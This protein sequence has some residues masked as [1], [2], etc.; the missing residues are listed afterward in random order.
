MDSQTSR[1]IIVAGSMAAV[2]GIGVATFALSSHHATSPAPNSQIPP[3]VAS[4]T[5]APVAV[6]SPPDT[7]AAVTPITDAPAV[8]YN[9][10]VGPK[11]GEATNPAGVEPNVAANRRLA[12]APTR[13]DSDA[14]VV[15]PAEPSADEAQP[16]SVDEVTTPPA[17]GGGSTDAQAGAESITP[18]APDAGAPP[19]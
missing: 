17:A 15:R 6:A 13:A 3:T 10:T 9:E 1:K 11:I 16:K 19:K 7:A 4:T 5:D 14:R 12:K 18:A 2:I 8:A